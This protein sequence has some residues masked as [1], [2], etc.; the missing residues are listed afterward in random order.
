MIVSLRSAPGFSFSKSLP[1]NVRCKFFPF[2]VGKSNV[3]YLCFDFLLVSTFT[4]STLLLI[5]FNN[6][7]CSAICLLNIPSVLIL[8]IHILFCTASFIPSKSF[9]SILAFT[10]SQRVKIVSF[11]DT[12][13]STMSFSSDNNL[14][15]YLRQSIYTASLCITSLVTPYLSSSS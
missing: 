3:F 15:H 8:D 9:Y 11:S 13:S 2:L 7:D 6:R 5:S 14:H 12:I 10:S 4:Y 1:R